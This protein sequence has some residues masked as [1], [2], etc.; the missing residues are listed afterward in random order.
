MRFVGF[1]VQP[2]VGSLSIPIL[3][4][5]KKCVKDLISTTDMIKL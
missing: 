1:I 4:V 2:A 5:L 3:N